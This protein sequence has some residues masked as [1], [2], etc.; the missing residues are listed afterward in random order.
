MVAS[1]GRLDEPFA[2]RMMS[3]RLSMVKQVVASL[4]TLLHSLCP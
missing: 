3:R 1:T 4:A 2:D